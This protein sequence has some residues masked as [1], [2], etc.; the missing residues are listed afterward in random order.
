MIALK[1][2]KLS[3][4][5]GGIGNCFMTCVASILGKRIEDVPN[6]ETLFIL[7]EFWLEVFNKWLWYHNLEY[8]LINEDE[9]IDGEPYLANGMT[10]R[11]TMH[12]VIYLN[13]KLFHDPHPSNSGLVDVKYYSAIRDLK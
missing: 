12:S 1:Q 7:G 6:V 11:N 13:G 8:V 5:N 10:E 3:G 2:T 4:E 9:W